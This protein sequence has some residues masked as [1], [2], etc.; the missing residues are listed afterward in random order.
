MTRLS[1]WWQTFRV[2]FPAMR[3]LIRHRHHEGFLSSL[4]GESFSFWCGAHMEGF[5]YNI[6]GLVRERQRQNHEWL[7]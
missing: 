3:F 4:G 2:W 5:G 6:E 1:D 7:P